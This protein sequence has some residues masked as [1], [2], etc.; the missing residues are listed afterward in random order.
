MKV[1]T[2]PGV[3]F[4]K[5]SPALSRLLGQLLLLD[6]PGEAVVTAGSDGK[7]MVGSKHYTG[8]AIDIRSWNLSDVKAFVDAYQ[9]ALGPKFSVIIEPD[10]IHAQ[11]R[12]GLTYP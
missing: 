11:V 1:S 12:K 9:K 4:D 5:E 10:H 2:K 7:H 3:R 8:N 6:Y